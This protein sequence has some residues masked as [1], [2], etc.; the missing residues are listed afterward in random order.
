ME[1]LIEGVRNIYHKNC[2]KFLEQNNLLI[3]NVK[4]NKYP[5]IKP[6]FNLKNNTI[7]ELVKNVYKMNCSDLNTIFDSK[8]KY[9]INVQLLLL[10]YYS[11]CNDKNLSLIVLK[12]KEIDKKEDIFYKLQIKISKKQLNFIDLQI[13]FMRMS[14][15]NFCSYLYENM[16]EFKSA[17]ISK[18]KETKKTINLNIYVIRKEKNKYKNAI[19]Q[20]NNFYEL[21]E[22]SKIFLHMPNYDVYEKQLSYMYGMDYENTVRVF[23]RIRFLKFYLYT[24][25]SLLEMEYFLVSGSYLLFC[26]GMRI[27]K[28]TDI[29]SLEGPNVRLLNKNI[30]CNYDVKYII[31]RISFTTNDIP[32]YDDWNTIILYPEDNCILFGLKTNSIR[33][34]IY[35]RQG[36]FHSQ[37]SKKALADLL[38]LKY[39]LNEKLDNIDV[40]KI[41]K[42]DNIL[43]YRYKNFN[44]KKIIDHFY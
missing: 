12:N 10:R 15:D 41:N 13:N 5:D 7:S 18:F 33:I 11:S 39:F 9:D 14:F 4:Y 2:R 17:N 36:R 23:F 16:E 27:S 21:V 8:S 25:Y 43:Y 28:D 31:D 42:F 19:F 38:V 30:S 34:E 26:L 20:S 3:E 32:P 37:N 44:K 29:Y 35:K 40:K 22:G 6:L 1:Y 24:H